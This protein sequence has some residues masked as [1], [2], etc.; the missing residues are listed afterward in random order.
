MKKNKGVTEI[1]V[2]LKRIVTLMAI[3][4]MLFL[5]L[6]TKVVNSAED[7]PFGMH[8]ITRFFTNKPID[9]QTTKLA[10]AAGVKWT[11]VTP[12]WPT[13]ESQDNQYNFKA[14]DYKLTLIKENNIIPYIMF[15][16][17]GTCPDWLTSAPSGESSNGYPPRNDGDWKSWRDFVSQ[18]VSRYG[19]GPGGKCLVTYW[20]IWSEPEAGYW[21]EKGH[22][23]QEF[24]SFLQAAHDTIMAIDPNAKI[25][26]S[27]FKGYTVQKLNT[28][29]FNNQP[30]DE[31]R[32]IKDVFELGAGQYFDVFSI[33]G[34]YACD[35]KEGTHSSLQS[36]YGNARALMNHYG[37]GQ[38][39]IW[40]TETGCTS[41]LNDDGISDSSEVELKQ[42]EDIKNLYERAINIG[43]SKVF[44]RY[45]EETPGAGIQGFYG[46]LRRDTLE[47]KPAYYAYCEV[48]GQFV[49][50][51]S[52]SDNIKWLSYCSSDDKACCSEESCV[53]RT[54]GKCYPPNGAYLQNDTSTDKIAYC[55]P[56]LKWTDC[57]VG[58]WK[59]DGAD[60][61]GGAIG[62]CPN[63]KCWI[64]AGESDVGE[65]LD[66][67]TAQCCGDDAYEKH[68]GGTDGTY[69][70]CDSRDTTGNNLNSP[71]CVLGGKCMDRKVIAEI[72]NNEID[73]N[74]DGTIN[75]GCGLYTECTETDWSH[76]DG[77]CQPNSTAVRTWTKLTDCQGG[78]THPSTEAIT[79]TFNPPIPGDVDRNG[80]V[81]VED[82]ALTG[83]NFGKTSNFDQRTDVNN[84]GKVDLLDLIIVAIHLGT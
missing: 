58:A 38:K 62:N 51:C 29:N 21:R 28:Q 67:N 30:D 25:I 37:L 69:A 52:A 49:S 14:L 41:D 78:I 15:V 20:E 7:S 33:G 56:T 71:E 64:K 13:I 72:C 82:L 66:Q 18:M 4:F 24:V 83:T 6:V 63:N 34:P 53:D 39:P 12:S 81:D 32:F 80:K 22:T 11:R 31:T 26:L 42:A 17:A 84:D 65:Y 27:R 45:L 70:C 48:A 61:C 16:Y 76:S 8:D 5:P 59:C 9:N 55:L 35:W 75:E 77:E 43:F 23:A 74:C 10:Q 44:W 68:S 79:C 1:C 40:I 60:D 19:C 46:I 73:D 57:D 54:G 2:F 50:S 36:R 47:P 3:I